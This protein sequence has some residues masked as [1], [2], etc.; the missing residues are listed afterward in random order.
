MA[1]REHVLFIYSFDILNMASGGVASAACMALSFAKCEHKCEEKKLTTVLLKSTLME[2]FEEHHGEVDPKKFQVTMRCS[3]K[4]QPGNWQ[5]DSYT[6]DSP[7]LTAADVTN[8]GVK[9]VR[10]EC[11]PT[12]S[13]HGIKLH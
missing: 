11:R 12:C 1:R 9:A 7:S 3:A 4:T 10:F 8:F 2:V 6:V 5:S 13:S